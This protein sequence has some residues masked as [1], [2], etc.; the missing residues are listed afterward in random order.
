MLGFVRAQW[1]EKAPGTTEDA[2]R[3]IV[4]VRCDMSG[5]YRANQTA[6]SSPFL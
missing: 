1:G 6:E 2:A 4:L 3:T 5:N